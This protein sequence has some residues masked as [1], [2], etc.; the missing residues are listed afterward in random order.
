VKNKVIE[1]YFLMSMPTH[2]WSCFSYLVG[3]LVGQSGSH[4]WRITFYWQFATDYV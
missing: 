1:I 4:I 2:M 3:W